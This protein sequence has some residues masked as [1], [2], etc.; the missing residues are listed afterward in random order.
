MLRG[1][2]RFLFTANDLH[3][4]GRTLDVVNVFLGSDALI[5]FGVLP[6]RFRQRDLR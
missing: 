2:V 6:R 5:N 1:E 4:I 3:H